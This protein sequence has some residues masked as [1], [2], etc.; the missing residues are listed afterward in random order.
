MG[1][2]GGAVELRPR[3]PE[4]EFGIS[5]NQGIGTSNYARSF[6]RLDSGNLPR[7]GTGLSLSL[8]H[9]DAEKWKGPG[10]LG[11]RK[12]ANLM[13]RQP[14]PTGDEIKFWFNANDLKQDLYRPL[15]YSEVTSLSRFYD[16]DYNTGLT[17]NKSE[18]I[19]YY[20]YNRGDYTNRDFLAELPVTLSDTFRFMLKPYYTDE[21]TDILQGSGSQA[22]LS[23][24]GSGTSK[25]TA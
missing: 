7:T 3:W 21:D 1:A 17:G 16:K 19:N 23:S 20:R 25:G 11:P 15:T 9:T 5:L 4:Q 12:N 18:D 24:N 10:D 2:R 14:L 8:S 22:A 13:V 6:I